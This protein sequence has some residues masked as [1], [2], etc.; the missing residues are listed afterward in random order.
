MAADRNRIVL[1][2]AMVLE[3]WMAIFS[4]Q[5]S[6]RNVVTSDGVF[7]GF[8]KAF[9]K[10]IIRAMAGW[11][12]FRSN[13]HS[14]RF[15]QATYQWKT[16]WRDALTRIDVNVAPETVRGVKGI[17]VNAFPHHFFRF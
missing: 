1:A 16:H 9:W 13:T 17:N 11:Q 12:V 15:K 3:E 14:N 8:Q 4:S 6:K 10:G 5:E 7:T 2:D